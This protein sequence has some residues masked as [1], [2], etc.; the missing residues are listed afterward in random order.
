MNGTIGFRLGRNVGECLEA[1]V[2]L[3]AT[4]AAVHWIFS[5][6]HP[7]LLGTLRWD[8][9]DWEYHRRS[10]RHCYNP[11][12]R[13][14][15]EVRASALFRAQRS[16]PSYIHLY[17]HQARWSTESSRHLGRCRQWFQLDM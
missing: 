3:N 10:R 11:R 9:F 5:Y 8:L 1:P 13:K 4:N 6:L 16:L 17:Y 12:L 15:E 7:F 2:P 14:C